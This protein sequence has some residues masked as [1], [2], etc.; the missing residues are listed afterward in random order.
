MDFVIRSIGRLVVDQDR[1]NDVGA[2]DIVRSRGTNSIVGAY[3]LLA[4]RSLPDWAAFTIQCNAVS[5]AATPGK[6]LIVA[7]D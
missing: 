5:R 2:S 1:L 6:I 3:A 7:D 4:L